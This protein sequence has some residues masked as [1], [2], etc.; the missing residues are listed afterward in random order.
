MAIVPP[1]DEKIREYLQFTPYAPD[2]PDKKKEFPK[3]F[4]KCYTY[5]VSAN[6]VMSGIPKQFMPLC[7]AF[8]ECM[9]GSEW[10]KTLLSTLGWSPF[11]WVNGP[12]AR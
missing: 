8:V 3:A 1:T 9:D 2:K 6:A 5:T 7:I 4:R 11:A 12:I 10:M